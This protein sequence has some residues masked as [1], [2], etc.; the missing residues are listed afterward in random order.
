MD[1]D[2]LQ[3]PELNMHHQVTR[4]AEGSVQDDELHGMYFY[5]RDSVLPSNQDDPKVS[6]SAEF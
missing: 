1:C 2:Q 6:L 3:T 4:T 5:S